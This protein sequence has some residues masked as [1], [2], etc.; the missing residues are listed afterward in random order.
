MSGYYYLGVGLLVL[1]V[2]VAAIGAAFLIANSGTGSTKQPWMWGVLIAG[3]VIAV[4][5]LVIWLF[6]AGSS[7][8]KIPVMPGD[9]MLVQQ[10]VSQ[11]KEMIQ[12]R[13]TSTYTKRPAPV[14]SRANNNLNPMSEQFYDVNIS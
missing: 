4:I 7:T 6:L 1:G 10:P 14:P 8:P 11:Q 2:I 5:G 12:E 13:T 9:D 3:I